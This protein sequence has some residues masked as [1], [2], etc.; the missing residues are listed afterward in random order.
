MKLRTL[1]ITVA[2]LAALSVAAY[3]ANR[4]ETAPPADARV[5]QALLDPDTAQKAAGITISDQGK[6]VE[7]DKAADGTWRVKSYFDFPADFEKIARLVQDL[8]EAKVERFVTASPDRLGHLEFKDSIIA[9]DDS[10]GKEIWSVTL[11]KTPDSGNGRFIRF[12]SE[13]KA[14]FSGMHVWLDTD[15][16]GWASAQLVSVKPEDVSGIEIPFD[17]GAPVVVTR[18]KKD[19]PWTAAGAPAG[20][21]LLADKVSALLTSLTALRFSDTT[22]PRDPAAA[23]AA[24]HMRTFKLTTFGGQTLSVS[25]GRKPEEKKLKPP[26]ADKGA[27]ASLAKPEDAKADAKPITPEFDTVPA[28]PVFAVVSS[29]E[30]KAPINDLM[31]RRAFEVDEFTFTGLPQK[32][33][34]LFEAEKAK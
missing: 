11:G 32:A 9:L 18:A 34:E 6:K 5:G 14:Y 8:N 27:L 20:Q 30:A 1:A 21:K 13:A 22:D 29:S 17:S 24:A 16:K 28:G 25:L 2:V 12:G 33:D 26:V 15:A 7:L 31:G 23:E 10:S 3:L 19:A 4:P